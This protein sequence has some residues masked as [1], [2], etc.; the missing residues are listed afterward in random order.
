MTVHEAAMHDACR[1]QPY[2]RR[3]ADACNGIAWPQ[4]KKRK[5]VCMYVCMHVCMCAC[6]RSSI[7]V[8]FA[9]IRL[10][11]SKVQTPTMAEISIEISLSCAPQKLCTLTKKWYCARPKPGQERMVGGGVQI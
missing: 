4:R 10:P 5:Y 6:M 9:A 3:A 2:N 7:M 1:E 8:T 11:M